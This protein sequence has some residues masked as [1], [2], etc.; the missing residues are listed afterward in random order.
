MVLLLFL[1]RFI[2]RA[3]VI[4]VDYKLYHLIAIGSFLARV[5]MRLSGCL[6]PQLS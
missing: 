2:R 1:V 5:I 3:A 4:C 6:S